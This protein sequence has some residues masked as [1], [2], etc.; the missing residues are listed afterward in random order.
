LNTLKPNWFG[1]EI[2]NALRARREKNA[3]QHNK[4]IEIDPAMLELIQQS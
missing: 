2:L 4:F 3:E 1:G